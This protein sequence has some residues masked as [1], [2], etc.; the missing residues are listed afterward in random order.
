LQLQVGESVKWVIRGA[1]FR[2]AKDFFVVF[3]KNLVMPHFPVI[4][5]RA[6]TA[7]TSENAGQKDNPFRKTLVLILFEF[8]TNYR[9][10]IF[11]LLTSAKDM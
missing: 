6:I 5:R 2:Q 1:D 7:L 3:Q 10:L 8:T 4:N 9:I 11:K